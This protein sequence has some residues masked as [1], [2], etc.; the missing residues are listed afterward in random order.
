MLGKLGKFVRK[1]GNRG[2]L[3]D[4][5]AV[6]LSNV[7]VLTFFIC[8]HTPLF[9]RIHPSISA[10]CVGAALVQLLRFTHTSGMLIKTLHMSVQHARRSV[11][12]M[13]CAKYQ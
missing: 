2:M 10:H 1:S 7:Y 6:Y 3:H 11:L 5:T 12:S 8:S 4:T 9:T 13:V